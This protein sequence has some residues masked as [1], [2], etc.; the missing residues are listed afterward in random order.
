M[1]AAYIEQTGS[2]EVIKVGELPR[3]TPGLGEVLVRVRAVAL[4]PID[5]YLRSGTIA[6]PR[7]FPY[8]VGCDLAG[9][10]VGV[11][12]GANRFREG[13]RVW[14]SN[15][16]LVGRQGVAAEFASVAEEW[17]QPTPANVS[18]S[19]AAAC[20]LV[21][22]TA[23]LGL[24]AFGRLQQGESVYVPGGAGGVGSMVLQ[25]AKISGARVATSAGSEQ[26]VGVCR[27]LGADAVYNY[28]SADIPASLKEFAPE[29]LDL[30][31][32]TQREPNLEA[33]VPLLRKRGRIIL[34]AGR[35]AKSLLP[36]GPLYTR[37]AAIL[38]F[39]MFN[40]SAIEQAPAMQAISDWLAQERLRPLIGQAFPLEAAGQAQRLLE[41]NTL[42]GAGTLSGKVVLSI[43]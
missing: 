11:G 37:D 9:E 8:I 13:D 35:T 19:A 23:W 7:P 27:E 5:L 28:K 1:R 31:Y 33:M 21:G 17:L 22:I 16:G 3:P 4:N 26:R 40:S 41:E 29:G 39:A 42:G 30:W 43:D 12:P 10:V 36:V 34:M 24:F 25:M 14:G 18:D 15:Q 6:L 32:E 38:G 2:P 20:A